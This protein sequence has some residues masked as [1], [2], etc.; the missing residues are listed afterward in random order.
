MAHINPA[1]LMLR[2]CFAVSAILSQYIAAALTSPFYSPI[3]DGNA[4][5]LAAY[6]RARALETSE[7]LD[8]S[9]LHFQILFVDEDNS[10][11]RIAEGLLARVAE[12]NDAMFILFPSST[13]LL[14]NQHESS[15][16]DASVSEGALSICKSLDLCSTR[17]ESLGT[18]FDLSYL[19]EYDLIIAMDDGIR[20]RILESLGSSEE[21]QG[22]YGPKCRLL[23]E[24]LS[25]DFCCS[26]KRYQNIDN[27]SNHD[28][29]KG[30]NGDKSKNSN[31]DHQLLLNMLDSELQDRVALFSDHVINI[32]RN[33][34]VFWKGRVPRNVIEIQSEPRI[35]MNDRGAAVPN[36]AEG[37]W[38]MVEG[39]MILASAG[40]TRFCLD[41]IDTQFETAFEAILRR[42]FYLVEH[43]NLSWD[44]ADEQLRRCSASVSG[45]FS[46]KYR[47]AKFK[48]HIAELSASL[49]Q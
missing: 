25:T 28:N 30:F 21:D 47:E 37:S 42:N 49:Q 38:P 7:S 24:F 13:T 4:F 39:A 46:P 12:Y 34:D 40:L 48:Q 33:N 26:G 23:S 16:R 44:K 18:S 5:S 14:A 19:D 22:Y 10:K 2:L 8:A 11:G 6:Q 3:N 45:Y 1:F 20:S 17:C 43:L 35:L 9:R 41:T 27:K 31:I 36:I 32:C 15:Y 29:D